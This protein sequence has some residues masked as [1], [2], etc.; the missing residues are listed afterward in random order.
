MTGDFTWA[1]CIQAADIS[2]LSM[3]RVFRDLELGSAGNLVWVRGTGP[4]PELETALRKIAGLIRF[5]LLPFGKLKPVSRRIPSGFLPGIQWKPLSEALAISLPP[6]GLPGESPRQMRIRLVRSGAELAPAVLATAVE[7]W[8]NYATS[9]P[10]IRLRHLTFAASNR[11]KV[12]IRG[13]P[14]PPLRG[15]PFTERDG[16][17]VPNGLTWDPPVSGAV[18][19]EVFAVPA[20]H[21][22]VLEKEDSYFSLRAEQFVPATRGAARATADQFGI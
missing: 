4:G 22:V 8:R 2:R 14:L 12:F 6:A 18:L 17:I 21:L 3:L 19:R 11:G 16:I 10:A 20:G 5:D 15:M 1:G 7:A 13:S 9:A